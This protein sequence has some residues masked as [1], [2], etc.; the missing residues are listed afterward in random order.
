MQVDAIRATSR[1]PRCSAEVPSSN[2][3]LHKL[4]C[5]NI[6]D[7]PV[8]VAVEHPAPPESPLPSASAH[9]APVA[10]S[11]PS[12]AELAR[13]FQA[14]E[15]GISAGLSAVAALDVSDV[16]CESLRLAMELQASEEAAAYHQWCSRDAELASERLARELQAQEEQA[17]S[18]RGPASGWHGHEMDRELAS[19]LAADDRTTAEAAGEAEAR[20]LDAEERAEEAIRRAERA[21][22]AAR[23]AEEARQAETRQ[24]ELALESARAASSFATASAAHGGGGD[25]DVSSTDD[26]WT[27]LAAGIE[28]EQRLVA[29]FEARQTDCADGSDRS[30]DDVKLEIVPN[31]VVKVNNPQL[32]NQF[33]SSSRLNALNDQA[34]C[35]DHGDTFLFHGAPQHAHANILAVGLTT[36]RAD[37]R[38]MLGGGIYGAPD[39]RKSLQYTGSFGAAG[40]FGAGRGTAFGG[41]PPPPSAMATAP[42]GSVFGMP[43]SG[44]PGGL[45]S[46]GHLR[47]PMGAAK[48]AGPPHRPLPTGRLVGVGLDNPDGAFM[49][50]CRYNLDGARSQHN[51]R[52]SEYCIF[53]DRHVAVLWLVKVRRRAEF[54]N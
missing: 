41:A 10:E 2:M 35:N 47:A 36:A 31:T 4:R 14:Q 49:L 5:Q 34:A 27:R 30:M 50:V 18:R 54:R 16:D 22:S 9:T 45:P 33:R 8:P 28:T 38:G 51:R 13:V 1:C 6:A 32:L 26:I 15:Y 12:D 29:F 25:H 42:T 44:T 21:E 23:S 20:R 40:A 52:F 53:E 11:T 17:A 39:P 19:Q 24:L 3:E 48:P 46:V 37:S 7:S 43:F